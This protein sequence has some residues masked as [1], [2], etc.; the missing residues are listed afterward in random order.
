[1]GGTYEQVSLTIINTLGNVGGI[2]CDGAKPSCAAKIAS[3][4]DAALGFPSQHTEQK[5]SARRRPHQGRCGGNHQEHG[6]YR[7]SRYEDY[8]YGNPQCYD[9][10]RQCGSVLLN[11]PS[12]KEPDFYIWFFSLLINPPSFSCFSS[13][14]STA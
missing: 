9:R 7:Q 5:L 13:P 6:L 1:Y 14:F 11:P 12:R 2:V 10:P 3:S 8:R 4:V